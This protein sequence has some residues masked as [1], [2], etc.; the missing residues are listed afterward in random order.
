VQVAHGS[1]L[2]TLFLHFFSSTAP[3]AT[4][5]MSRIQ[6]LPDDF[7]DSINL[8]EGPSDPSIEELYQQHISAPEQKHISSKTFEEIVQD[9]SKTPLFM[10]SLE[11]ATDEGTPDS[12]AAQAFG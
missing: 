11:E 6:G 10:N 12:M 5:T 4:I 1:S 2:D 3:S 8:N 7:D 9:M